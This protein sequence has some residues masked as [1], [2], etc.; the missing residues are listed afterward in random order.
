MRKTLTLFLIPV[1]LSLFAVASA[2]LPPE[3]MV[4]KHLMQAEQRLEKKDY[5]GAFKEMET[6]IALQK[7][8]NLTLPDAFLFRYAQVALKVGELQTAID[9]VNKYLVTAGERGRVLQRGSGVVDQD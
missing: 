9:A 2:Q 4:D 6:V 1:F 5:L 3:I 8:H 7:E